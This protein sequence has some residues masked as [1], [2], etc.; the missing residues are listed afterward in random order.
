M[1]IFFKLPKTLEQ[2]KMC[3]LV[4]LVQTKIPCL[5]KK[6]VHSALLP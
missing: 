6:N 3:E 1:C 4:F 5:E 2:G